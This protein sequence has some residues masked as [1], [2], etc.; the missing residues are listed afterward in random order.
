M[1]RRRLLTTPGVA[2]IEITGP[3]FLNISLDGQGQ[4]VALVREILRCGPAYGHLERP[5]SG[6]RDAG[7]SSATLHLRIA[8][9]VRAAVVADSVALILRSQGV[10]GRLRYEDVAGPDPAWAAL[11]VVTVRH[12]DDAGRPSDRNS[13]SSDSNSASEGNSGSDVAPAPPGTVVLIRPTP[14]PADPLPLGRDAG[15][16]ALLLPAAHD[17]PRIGAEHLAQRED[18]PL[19]RVRYAHARTRALLRNAADLGFSPVPG[20]PEPIVTTTRC[21]DS[22]TTRSSDSV[23]DGPDDGQS[24]PAGPAGDA[25]PAGIARPGN[26]A[27]PPLTPLSTALADYPVALA[28]AARHRAP[29]RLARHLIRVA[30]AFLWFQGFQETVP[31]LP[32]GDEKPS[33]AH[34]ARLALAEAT[35]TVLAGGLA[36]LGIDAPDHI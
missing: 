33:A 30:D 3:G 28:A 8:P 24:A 22:T 9:G 5:G 35:G 31:I 34:R 12:P 2:G 27:A 32:R 15:R 29:D 18:N 4:V 14:A 16:W 6:V 11:G 10:T 23:T 13:T 36:L 19:F 25:A 1:L 21:S 7:H 26:P 20:D 17:R